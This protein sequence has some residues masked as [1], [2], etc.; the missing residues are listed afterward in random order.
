MWVLGV[1]G[2]LIL[3]AMAHSLPAAL[4]LAIVGA[5]GCWVDQFWPSLRMTCGQNSG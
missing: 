3:G 4:V 1:I 2:G 5:A